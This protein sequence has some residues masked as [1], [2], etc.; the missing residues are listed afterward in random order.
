MWDLRSDF[1]SFNANFGGTNFF[2][3]TILSMSRKNGIW[4]L[5]MGSLGMGLVVRVTDLVRM[6]SLPDAASVWLL[7]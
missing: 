4:Y 1:L 2:G 7:R 6:M 5:R 3:G